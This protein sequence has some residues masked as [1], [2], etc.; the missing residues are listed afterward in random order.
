VRVDVCFVQVAQGFLQ[1][2]WPGLEDEPSMFSVRPTCVV[3]NR[4]TQLKGHVEAWGWRRSPVQLNPGHIV[5]GILTGFHE[6]QNPVQTASTAGD[7]ESRPWDQT[8]RAGAG[9]VGEK[10]TAETIVEGGFR[11]ID[12]CLAALARPSRDGPCAIAPG[13]ASAAAAS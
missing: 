3:P 11:K 12:F 6:R 4:K 1:P 7:L 13:L 8:E 9:D 2:P 10:E 5:N